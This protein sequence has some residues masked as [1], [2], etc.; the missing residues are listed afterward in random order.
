MGNLYTVYIKVRHSEDQF[1]M[2]GNQ[3]GFN[4]NTV[5]DAMYPASQVRT[6]LNDYFSLYK[7]LEENLVY[8]QLTFKQ[9]DIK[10]LSEFKIEKPSHIP[11]SYTDRIKRG[12]NIPMSVDKTYLGK[13]LNLVIQDGNLTNIELNLSGVIVNFLDIIRAKAKFLKPK[14]SDNIVSFDSG[15]S[16]YLLRDYTNYILAIKTLGSY[17]IHKIRYS[18]DGVVINNVT[19]RYISNNKVIRSVG[20]KEM[21]LVDNKMVKVTTNISLKAL[22][23]PKINILR[24]TNPNIGSIDTETYLDDDGIRKIY[25][26]GFRTNLEDTPHIYYVDKEDMNSDKIVLK[27][28]DELLRTKYSDI[29]FYCHNLGGY[30]VVFLL[31]VLYNY[32]DRNEDKYKISPLLKDD[33]IIKVVISKG[34]KSFTIVDSYSILNSSLAKLGKDFEVST[35]KTYFPYK[36]ATRGNL[37]YKGVTPD[38]NYYNNITMEQYANLHISYWSFYDA[39]LDYLSNDLNSL[40]EIIV[41]ANRQVFLDYNVDMTESATISSLAV[42]IFMKNFYKENIPNINKLSLYTDIKQAYYGGITEVYKPCG[43]NLYYYDVNSLYPFVALNPMPGLVCS[44][45]EYFDSTNNIQNLFGFFYCSIETP[46]NLYMGLLPVRNQDGIEL[47]LGN[48]EGWY[49]SEELK[50]A[51]SKGYKIK[52]LKG[53]NF[54]KESGVFDEYV[55]KIYQIKSNPINNTQ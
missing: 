29:T 33:N 2:A 21:V 28:V 5:D 42:N 26:L 14:H 4:F 48:W 40:Y 11:I 39:T 22:D 45:I 32:N 9:Q 54:S 46:L 35:I 16:F 52:V 34:Y 49:F 37:F 12:L 3:F 18:I 55:N 13:P 30:D 50:F 6:R 41:K 51:E 38:I 10:L 20:N 43:Y 19:D 24:I 7:I 31:K 8:V 17:S 15:Y 47:P 53:Y 44:K 1:F 36:F 25:A 23:K 27:M